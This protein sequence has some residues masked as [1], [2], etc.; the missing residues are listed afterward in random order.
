MS[1]KIRDIL[2]VQSMRRTKRLRQFKLS[3]NNID[4]D[5]ILHALRPRSQQ[6]RQTHSTHTKNNKSTVG[7]G[8][9]NIEDSPGTSEISTTQWSQNSHILNS[10]T[11][12]RR[13]LD[14]GVFSDNGQLAH[15]GLAE[16]L[17]T[18]RTFSTRERDRR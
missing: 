6:S 3:I 13:S 1:R 18:Q 8:L 5:D 2:R 17:A 14:N 11:R 12:A 4:R 15:R 16:E 9:E 7:L 10:N